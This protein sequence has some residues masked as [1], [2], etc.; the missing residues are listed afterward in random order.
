MVENVPII[1]ELPQKN[2]QDTFNK[3]KRM[4]LIRHLTIFFFEII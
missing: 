4:L 3:K 1:E 2:S